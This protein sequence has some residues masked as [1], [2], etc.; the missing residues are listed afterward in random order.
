VIYVYVKLIMK[1]GIYSSTDVGPKHNGLDYDSALGCT[2]SG[3]MRSSRNAMIG[4]ELWRSCTKYEHRTTREVA[5]YGH[6]YLRW[7][8]A[9]NSCDQA[10]RR[11]SIQTSQLPV[12]YP[13]DRNS[14]EQSRL[15]LGRPFGDLREAAKAKSPHALLA[16]MDWSEQPTQRVPDMGEILR[17][18]GEDENTLLQ[19]S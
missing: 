12:I 9:V 7:H 14:P 11:R 17:C 16:G 1:V 15:V 6:A 13:Q 2:P 5:K 4:H 10:R 19:P 8:D 18:D 3:S